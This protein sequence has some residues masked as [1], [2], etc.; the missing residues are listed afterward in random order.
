MSSLALL[1][2]EV[3][4]YA[5]GRTLCHVWILVALEEARQWGWVLLSPSPH[6]ATDPCFIYKP[7]GVC[8]AD[9]SLLLPG[10]V[11]RGAGPYCIV[12]LH[13]PSWY[14]GWGSTGP[15]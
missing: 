8:G 6:Q 9:L 12:W 15:A 13:I 11:S 1:K 3:S 2:S 4:S 5:A 10:L 14:K 7:L